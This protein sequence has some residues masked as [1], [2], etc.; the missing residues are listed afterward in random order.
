MMPFLM[1]TVMVRGRCALRNASNSPSD[2][3]TGTPQ[4]YLEVNPTTN[5]GERT[6]NNVTY[7]THY[8][9]V[10]LTEATC[11]HPTPLRSISSLTDSRSIPG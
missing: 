10:G 4:E 11:A 9:K 7:R 8:T 6:I 1:C 3:A 5:Y 2:M